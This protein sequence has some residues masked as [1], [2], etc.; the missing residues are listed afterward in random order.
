MKLIRRILFALLPIVLL[1]GA[2][3]V[4]VILRPLPSLMEQ[5]GLPLTSIRGIAITDSFTDPLGY[6][7]G[8]DYAVLQVDPSAFT[9]PESWQQG[10]IAVQEANP[11]PEGL[12]NGDFHP[13]FYR[14][15]PLPESLTHW[16]FVP[17]DPSLPFEEQMKLLFRVT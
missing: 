3:R 15:A 5:A 6:T 8:Y 4:Y 9:P 17:R 16:L 7:D 10:S 11:A 14:D 2:W 13:N 1:I 12:G